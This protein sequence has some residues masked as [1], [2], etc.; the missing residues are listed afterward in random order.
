M[1]IRQQFCPVIVSTDRQW[2]R[3]TQGNCGRW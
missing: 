1:N 3:L 2:D